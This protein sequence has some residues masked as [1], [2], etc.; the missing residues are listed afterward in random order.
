MAM[1]TK[2]TG[3]K[4]RKVIGSRYAVGPDQARQWLVEIVPGSFVIEGARMRSEA[5]RLA[6]ESI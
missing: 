2:L 5:T 1:K 3:H 6:V 4:G